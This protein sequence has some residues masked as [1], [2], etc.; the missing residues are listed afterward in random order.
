MV[1]KN[2]KLLL[3]LK[4]QYKQ[5]SGTEWKPTETVDGNKLNR[6]IT[7][8]GDKVRDLKASKAPKESVDQEVKALLGLKAQYKQATGSEWKPNASP[9]A[10][11]VNTDQLNDKIS[12]QGDKVRDM[13]ARKAAK[14]EVD[15]AVKVLLELKAKYKEVSSG[16]VTFF[17]LFMFRHRYH[18]VPHHRNKKC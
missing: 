15:A 18:K 4:S 10:V 13:K 17:M 3:E 6:E 5:A 9:A 1:E 7:A 11:A 2:V 8:Q 12:S 16:N 14:G